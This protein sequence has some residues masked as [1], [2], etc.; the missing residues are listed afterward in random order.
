[1]LLALKLAGGVGL[2]LYGMLQMGEGLQKAAGD[3]LR[4][5]L[6]A[7]TSRPWMGVLVGAAVTAV[8]QSSGATTVMTVSFVNAG[9]MTLRQAVGVIMGANIGTTAT[10]QLVAF[11][12]TSWALPAVG[13]G[14]A[15]QVGAR[16]KVH[17]YLGQ[18]VLGFG[19]LFLGMNTM[20]E[21]MVPLRDSPFFMRLMTGLGRNPLAGVLVGAAMTVCVQSSSA[22]IGVL[23]ALAMQ[24]LVSLN[25]ALPILFGDNIGTCV[26]ALLASVGTGVTARRSALAHLLFNVF[27]TATFLVLLPAFRWI[28]LHVSPAGDVARQIANA[29]TSF[30]VLNTLIW[31]PLVNQLARIVTRLAPGEEAPLGRGPQFLDKRMLQTPPVALELATREIMRMADITRGML[32]AAREAF[33]RN[34]P[35]LAS[36]LDN[37][38]EI[39]DTLQAEVILYL[40]TLLSQRELTEQQSS[41]VAALMRAVSDV[42]RVGDHA[43]NI[44]GFAVERFESA[45][46]F[47]EPAIL[48]L[49][50][51]FAHVE[52]MYAQA[53]EAFRTGDRELA[54]AV[55]TR[56]REVDRFEDS[57]RR[58]HLRRL[59]EGTC[60]PGS[61]VVYVELL[62]NLE[63]VADHATNLADGV[64]G[65]TEESVPVP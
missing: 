18:T 50:D 52:D 28:V 37:E 46:P 7:L 44:K 29:H 32:A 3:R 5:I 58:N 60:F 40:S 24:R 64:L 14:F 41:L 17:R 4:R 20:T 51:M 13:L 2:F 22:T 54:E 62:D 56:E 42:E 38:E 1:M 9:L 8:I 49:Q 26:T 45:L 21:A 6:E 19:L 33:L 43:D 53:I 11:R 47:S 31:L 61:G 35:G 23:Q 48:E 15:I 57:L 39:V 65:K 27:G 59:N 12:L 16:R 63:R 34:N 10:A 25:T 30:N 36:S 55:W